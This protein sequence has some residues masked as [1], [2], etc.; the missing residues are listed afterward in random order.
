MQWHKTLILKFQ[1]AQKLLG[2]SPVNRLCPKNGSDPSWVVLDFSGQTTG[3]GSD[4]FFGQSSV[5]HLCGGGE[6]LHYRCQYSGVPYFGLRFGGDFFL[7]WMERLETFVLVA[8]VSLD[9]RLGVAKAFDNGLVVLFFDVA[10]LLTDL[11]FV[12]DVVRIAAF[13]IGFFGVDVSTAVAIMAP[14]SV[15]LSAVAVFFV[16]LFVAVDFRGLLSLATGVFVGSETVPATSSSIPKSSPR[17][18]PASAL[19]F[20]DASDFCR[21]SAETA[22]PINSR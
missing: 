4:P 21:L 13:R 20:A 5:N 6:V 14:L 9:S 3:R 10:A 19:S 1:I 22:A 7:V 16:V 18:L 12:T 11:A 15:L 8:D 17:S 2:E